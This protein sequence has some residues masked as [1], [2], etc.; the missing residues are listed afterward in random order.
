MVRSHWKSKTL[1]YRPKPQVLAMDSGF[2]LALTV[3]GVEVRG[4]KLPDLF[5]SRL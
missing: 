1:R 5:E 4:V 3:S 2:I